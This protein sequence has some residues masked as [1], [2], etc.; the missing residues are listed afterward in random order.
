MITPFE[1][2]HVTLQ[3]SNLQKTKSHLE[4]IFDFKF[5]P[6]PASRNML[7]IESENVHFFIE[8]STWPKSFLSKQ[9]ISFE[10]KD[11][12]DIRKKLEQMNI[13][14]KSGTFSSFKY[15]NY[16]WIEWHDHDGIRL[17]CVQ[18]I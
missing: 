7:A 14:Y 6:D 10:I 18:R 17:E 15:K 11:A 12:N 5:F 13:E 3:V 4:S 1:I 16:H 9:H 2:D 8:E